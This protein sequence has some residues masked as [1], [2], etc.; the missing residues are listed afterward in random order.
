MRNA[1]PDSGSEENRRS[2]ERLTSKDCAYQF[3]TFF[4]DGIAWRLCGSSSSSL[5]RWARRTGSSSVQK[6]SHV[7][8]EQQRGRACEEL[9]SLEQSPLTRILAEQNHLLEGDYVVSRQCPLE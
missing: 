6:V 3:L 1:S 4:I 7:H 2:R 8:H 5:T 9:A